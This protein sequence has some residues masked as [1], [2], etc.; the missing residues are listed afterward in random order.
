MNLLSFYASLHMKQPLKSL[1]CSFIGAVVMLAATL[2]SAL[3]VVIYPTPQLNGTRSVTTK[4]K[5]VRVIM[6]SSGDQSAMWQRL[7]N[8]AD[9]YAINITPAN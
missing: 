3:A 5:E 1:C 2:P 9:G 8:V 7:P 6:R 4:V